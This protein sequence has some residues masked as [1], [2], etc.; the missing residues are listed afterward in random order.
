M[1]LEQLAG[2]TPSSGILRFRL[3][4]AASPSRERWGLLLN[5]GIPRQNFLQQMRRAH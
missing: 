4:G 2:P 1:L 5:S 3:L